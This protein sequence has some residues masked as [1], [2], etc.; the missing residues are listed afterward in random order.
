MTR[1]ANRKN[2][3]RERILQHAWTL[4]TAFPNCTEQGPELCK[5]L[6]RIETKVHREAENL[7]NYPDAILAD[8]EKGERFKKRQL[9]RVCEL[10]GISPE[11]KIVFLNLDPRGHAVKLDPD[12]TRRYNEEQPRERRLVTDWGDYGIV[13][14]QL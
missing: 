7:C 4:Q 9:E 1:T 13:A 10:L 8:E 5:K 11:D 14:P 6:R 12:W 3:Q 2:Q